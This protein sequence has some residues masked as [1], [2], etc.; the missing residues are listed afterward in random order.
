MKTPQTSWKMSFL[1]LLLTPFL[2]TAQTAVPNQSDNYPLYT[3]LDTTYF[4]NVQITT[5]DKDWNMNVN[6]KTLLEY[7]QRLE[8]FLEKNDP[9]AIYLYAECHCHLVNTEFN[10]NTADLDK[11]VD[12]STDTSYLLNQKKCLKYLQRADGMN[13]AWATWILYNEYRMS[14]WLTNNDKVAWHYLQKTVKSGDHKLK[15]FAYAQL[16]N[17]YLPNNNEAGKNPDFPVVHYDIDKGLHY[18]MLYYELNPN[19]DMKVLAEQ[20]RKYGRFDEAID[21]YLRSKDWRMHYAAGA[22]LILGYFVKDEL[23]TQD[24]KRGLGIIHNLIKQESTKPNGGQSARMISLLNRLHYCYCDEF[25]DLYGSGESE[26]C[27]ELISK[28][29]VGKYYIEN[30]NCP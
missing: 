4:N 2:T 21:I 30:F 7:K 5:R 6:V 22:A 9:W 27:P 13:V 25:S 15:A 11:D 16:S 3:D 8:P 19:K 26:E 17:L 18:N 20:Y 23:V 12:I 14:D 28:E 1:F 10:Y 24:K 29:D